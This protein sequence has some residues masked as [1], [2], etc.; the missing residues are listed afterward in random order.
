[1]NNPPFNEWPLHPNKFDISRH[2]FELFPPAFVK[3]H[4]DALVEIAYANMAGTEKPDAAEPFSVF[5]LQKAADF[6][7]AKSKAGF[8]IYVGAALRKD[9]TIGRASDADFLNTCLSW[10]RLRQG[11]R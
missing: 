1:M 4:P 7:E 10:G 5:E 9:G 3:N 11:G 6:A 2:L 8:N